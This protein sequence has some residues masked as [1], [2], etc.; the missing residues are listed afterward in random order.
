MGVRSR[1]REYGSKCH[2]KYDKLYGADMEYT[3]LESMGYEEETTSPDDIP[4]DPKTTFEYVVENGTLLINTNNRWFT[5]NL[6]EVT[7]T[8]CH[9]KTLYSKADVEIEI[10]RDMKC[11]TFTFETN[12]T[13]HNYRKLQLDVNAFN[14][15]LTMKT[16]SGAIRYG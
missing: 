4:V 16:G 6:N 7:E 15:C 8:N 11:S 12:Y 13:K 5:Y 3:I 10:V 1:S 14:R 9:I 2:S